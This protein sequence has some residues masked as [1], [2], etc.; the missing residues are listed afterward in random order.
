M[1]VYDCLDV[2]HAAVAHLTFISVEYFVKGVDFLGNR[3]L[4][5]ERKIGIL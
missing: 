1:N 3:Y 5:G 2:L 4:L